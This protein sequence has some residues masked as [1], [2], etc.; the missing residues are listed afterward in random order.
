MRSKKI[1]NYTVKFEPNGEGGYLAI[2]PAFPEIQT[3][4]WTLTE[5]EAMANDAI[6]L[7]IEYYGEQGRPLPKDVSYKATKD[8]NFFKLKV[9]S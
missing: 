6:S 7:C 2:V 9:A 3:E 5:A 1:H 8:P 4:G